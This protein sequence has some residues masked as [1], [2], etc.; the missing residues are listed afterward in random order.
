MQNSVSAKNQVGNDSLVSPEMRLMTAWL[1]R[2]C[3]YK[4][5]S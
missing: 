2:R 1:A 3:D 4:F 5:V